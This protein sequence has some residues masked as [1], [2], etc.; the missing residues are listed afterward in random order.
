[1]PITVVVA[2]RTAEALTATTLLLNAES[3]VKLQV[4]FVETWSVAVHT[5]PR[6]VAVVLE[7]F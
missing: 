6:V 5:K 3:I 4:M 2:L 7:L 1:M